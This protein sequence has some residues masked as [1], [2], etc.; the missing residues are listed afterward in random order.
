MK[1][2]KKLDLLYKI[3]TFDNYQISKPPAKAS[4]E[5]DNKLSIM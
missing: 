2:L 5:K 1:I 4:Q 3:S